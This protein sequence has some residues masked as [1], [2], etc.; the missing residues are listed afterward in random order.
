MSSYIPVCNEMDEFKLKEKT[1]IKNQGYD[2]SKCVQYF[3][4]LL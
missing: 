2:Y 4:I 3:F 1:T